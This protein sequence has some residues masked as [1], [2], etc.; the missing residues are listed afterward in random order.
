MLQIEFYQKQRRIFS[1][2][3]IDIDLRP[4]YRPSLFSISS[5]PSRPRI[6]TRLLSF[7]SI[8]PTRHRPLRHRYRPLLCRHAL[9]LLC[10]IP[11]CSVSLDVE[12]HHRFRPLSRLRV[13]FP[14][15]FSCPNF[16]YFRLEFCK[17]S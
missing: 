4:R 8:Q 16:V 13:L 5:S 17:I 3:N 9:F 10:S 2:T 1:T 7:I 11:G 6:G 14:L 12:V 15:F